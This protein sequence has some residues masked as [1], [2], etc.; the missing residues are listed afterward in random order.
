[1]DSQAQHLCG[2]KEVIGMSPPRSVQTSHLMSCSPPRKEK[3]EN[4]KTILLR[5]VFKLII[6]ML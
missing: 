1:V 2:F 6:R 4:V 5:T 3:G